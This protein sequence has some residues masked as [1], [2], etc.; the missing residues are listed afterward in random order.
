H[1]LTYTLD[2]LDAAAKPKLLWD[3]TQH[4]FYPVTDDDAGRVWAFTTK[5]APLGRV[6]RFGLTT[7][8]ESGWT[9]VIPEARYSLEWVN[10]VGGTLFCGYLK[11]AHTQ[12][13]R[14]SLDGK[15]LG[16][17][18]LPG[19]GSAGG[20]SGRKHDKET[21]YSYTDMVT[22]TTMFRYDIASGK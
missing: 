13:L 14:Y 21:F 10:P 20:F 22:P 18:A 12:V 6:V 16:E 15:L 4:E 7:P 5:G 9:T 8:Q 11:D 3:D 19:K 2:L 1:G 17:V